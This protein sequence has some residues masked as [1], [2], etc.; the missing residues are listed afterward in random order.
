M[1]NPV[2]HSMS[3]YPLCCCVFLISCAAKLVAEAV[4]IKGP[5]K[6]FIPNSQDIPPN[7]NILQLMV[8]GRAED[9]N[10]GRLTA[11]DFSPMLSIG[12]VR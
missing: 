10:L 8:F 6:V 7:C 1:E 5:V 4:E 11:S 2:A 12:N 3:H 9:V